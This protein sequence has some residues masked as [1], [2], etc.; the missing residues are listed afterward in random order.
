M[1]SHSFHSQHANILYTVCL[2]FLVCQDKQHII[3]SLK[4]EGMPTQVDRQLYK[5]TTRGVFSL[6]VDI[7]AKVHI[8]FGKFQAWK[9]YINKNCVPQ[10]NRGRVNISNARERQRVY[11]LRF[12]K[13]EGLLLGVHCVAFL[14]CVHYVLEG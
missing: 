6:R 9:K 4:S 7:P 12:H 8:A 3:L 13:L 1:S 10:H 2:A 14:S 5:R 11:N